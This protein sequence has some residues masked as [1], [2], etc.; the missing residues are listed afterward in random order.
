MKTGDKFKV[1]KG[2]QKIGLAAHNFG[3]V[4]EITVVPDH[5]VR[6]VLAPTYG[7]KSVTVWARFAKTLE[8]EEFN[9]GCG[10]GI[11]TITVRVV[12]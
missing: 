3:R 9:L 5:G 10:D 6:V 2:N 1:V 11:N 7:P 8:R 4:H 12:K